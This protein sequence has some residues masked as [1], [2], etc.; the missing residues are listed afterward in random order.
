MAASIN[1]TSLTDTHEMD[2]AVIALSP[3]INAR[4]IWVEPLPGQD[5]LPERLRTWDDGPSTPLIETQL[6]LDDESVGEQTT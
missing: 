2:A 6:G 4:A 3:K 5:G 1:S